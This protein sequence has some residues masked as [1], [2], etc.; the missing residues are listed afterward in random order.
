MS[1]GQALAA[2]GAVLQTAAPGAL[3]ALL[4]ELVRC[5]DGAGW[6][7]P[8]H[9]GEEVGRFE[10]VREIGRG[11]FGVV[12]QA[13]DRG[14][15]RDVAFKAVRP[16]GVDPLREARLLG[17][18]EAAARLS[19]PNIVHLYDVGRCDRGAFLVLELL[20]GVRLADRIA[21]GALPVREAVRIAVEA[22]RGLAH[23]HTLGVVHRDVTPGNVFLC[24][25]GQVKVLDFGLAQVFGREA[26]A[27]GT[28]AYM[29]PEQA[30]GEPG[31]ERTDVFALGMLLHEMISGRLPFSG[32]RLA[33]G[34]ECAAT[35]LSGVPAPLARLVA[36]MLAGDPGHRPASAVEIHGELLRIQRRLEPRP[37]LWSAWAVAAAAL[38]IALG[39]ALRGR[40]APLPP[41]RLLVGLAD[42]ANSTGDPALDDLSIL[43]VTALEQS[44]RLSILARSRLLALLHP[45]GTGPHRI[46]EDALRAAALQA[47]AQAILMPAIRATGEGYAVELRG[48]DLDRDEPLFTLREQASA[49]GSIPDALDRLSDRAR[50]ELGDAA[51]ASVRLARVVPANPDAWRAYA[52]GQRLRSEG[53][54]DEALAAFERTLAVDP[55]FPLAHLQI[56]SRLRWRD[57]AAVERHLEAARRGLDRIPPRERLLFD[58]RAAA[59][60]WR[61]DDAAALYDRAIAGWP[62]DPAAY[63]EAGLLLHTEMYDPAR[64]KPYLEKA[65]G[66]GGLGLADMHSAEV[67]LGRLD[68]A[69][70]HARDAAT[71][72]PTRQTFTRLSQVHRLRGEAAE[73]LEAA[74]RAIAGDPR[75]IHPRQF[76][77]FVE[78]D[79]LDELEDEMRRRGELPLASSGPQATRRWELLALRGQHRAARAAIDASAPPAGAPPVAQNLYRAVRATFLA[80]DGNAD[81]VWRE[82]QAMLGGGGYM[83]VCYTIP[84]TALG[85]LERA[86][87]LASLWPV[88]DGS[89]HYCLTLYRHLRTWR[90]GDPEG[91]VR[92][93]AAMYGAEPTYMRGVIL[94]ELGRDREAIEAFQ[95]F[96]RAPDQDDNFDGGNV[97][98]YPHTLYL[99]AACLERLGDRSGARRVV[100]RLL[101]MWGRADPDAGGPGGLPLLREAKALRSRLAGRGEP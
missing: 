3:S 100:D 14:L 85:D 75:P 80:T 27:G 91:A 86:E 68:A 81:A 84:L 21:A 8:L 93:L 64:A 96:R 61:F 22:S 6:T 87:R 82:V 56:A 98:A 67:L 59:L 78:A 71:S 36:R 94:A 63:I 97:F 49:R 69:L 40:P 76:W 11:G 89:N 101:R 15:G 73:A 26:P 42:V 66:L 62:Q 74:R 4:V 57:E 25:D 7:R 52:E 20:R 70:A 16:S 55:E 19:H 44:S 24:D 30:R 13:H 37:L 60:R 9:P 2:E 53:R 34:T 43:L 77:A 90:T 45:P 95:R 41:G 47:R 72:S 31:D 79:A 46:G 5:P 18:A 88:H 39:F 29:A 50:A 12:Y 35:A 23:A 48:V 92:G 33:A 54:T 38:L 51:A 65:L 1:P 17:E 32:E 28:P 99:E 58:A 10:I 83:A